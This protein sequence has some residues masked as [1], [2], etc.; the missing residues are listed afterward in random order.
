MNRENIARAAHEINRAYCQ[1][2]GDDSQPTWE[3][4]P[5]WQ[6]KSALAGVDMHLA[7][8]DATPEQSHESWLAQKA[9]E[10]WVYGEVKDP[11]KKQHPCFLPYDELPL[12]QKAKDYLFRAVV[13]LLKDVPEAPAAEAPPTP[14][15]RLTGDVLVTYIGRK[16]DWR[17]HIYD[18]GLYFT[19]GQTRLLP[20][21]IAKRFLRHADLFALGE[22]TEQAAAVQP[23]TTPVDEPPKEDDD[24]DR[25]LEEAKA[26]QE[27]EREEERKRE[28]LLQSLDQM[29]KV[30]LE[31]FA[32]TKYNHELDRRKSLA[33]LR[34]EVSN[35]VDQF[36]IV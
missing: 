34:Q 2:L 3:D 29:D 30:A 15:P 11:E 6:Q 33:K 10:G 13:H 21:A 1:S 31:E 19:Q 24:T 12:E 23:A 18:T 35:L 14:A 32:R 9:A 28:D 5:E 25:I 26:R 20:A 22:I 36:G 16:P 27:T 8:P 7:N 17:D 4:A